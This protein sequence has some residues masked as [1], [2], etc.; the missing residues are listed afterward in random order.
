MIHFIY[1]IGFAL[2]VAVAF[3]VFS[4]GSEK[5]KVIYGI[6]IFGQFIGISLIMAWIFYFLPW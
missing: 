2:F 4:T 6:K 1:L 3:S 5:E